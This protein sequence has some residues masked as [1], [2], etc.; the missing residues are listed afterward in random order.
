M[1]S[2]ISKSSEAA[3]IEFHKVSAGWQTSNSCISRSIA[4]CTWPLSLIPGH[5][6][7]WCVASFI[8]R[9]QQR[10]CIMMTLMIQE[11]EELMV[12]IFMVNDETKM[13]MNISR[14]IFKIQVFLM[15]KLS[16]I[17]V[18]QK[19]NEKY[20]LRNVFKMESVVWK[21]NNKSY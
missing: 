11:I 9:R 7:L 5:S 17:L 16:N 4:G 10:S 14:N 3:N 12:T 21:I 8:I 6:C 19:I 18:L 2:Q 13:I 20:F 1:A 15:S